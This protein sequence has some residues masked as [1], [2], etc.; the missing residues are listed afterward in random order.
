MQKKEKYNEKILINHVHLELWLVFTNNII[1]RRR[2]STAAI[3]IY[4]K[5][6]KSWRIDMLIAEKS[7]TNWLYLEKHKIGQ[8]NSVGTVQAAALKKN[9]CLEL[10][11]KEILKNIMCWEDKHTCICLMLNSALRNFESTLSSHTEMRGII[12]STRLLPTSMYS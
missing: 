2:G 4:I 11:K 7:G 10:Q 1:N 3:I 8:K 12:G 9:C 5:P 6:A